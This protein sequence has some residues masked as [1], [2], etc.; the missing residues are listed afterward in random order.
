MLHLIKTSDTRYEVHTN[1][2]IYSGTVQECT[3][4][5]VEELD[6]DVAEIKIALA[7]MQKND[8]DMAVFGVFKN[9]IYS[10]MAATLIKFVPNF[11]PGGSSSGSAPAMFGTG[12]H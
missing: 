6:I 9:F 1:A 12:L 5:M 2:V 10:K 7:D 4:F 8:N 11:R 3:K